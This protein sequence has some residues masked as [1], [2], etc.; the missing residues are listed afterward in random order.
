MTIFS[1]AYIVILIVPGIIFKRFFFQ[2]AFSGQFNSGLFADRLI[3]SL[4]LGILVQIISVLTF[5]RIIN[6]SYEDWRTMLQTLYHNILQ[7]KF[8]D[9]TLRQLGN[10][11]LYAIYSVVLAASLG[12]ILYKFIR[13]LRLDLKLPA[14][15]FLNQWHYYFKG[16]ILGTPEFKE[17][18]RGKVIST[19][20]DLMLKNNDGESNLFSGLLTQYT[21][22][23][24]NELDTL[25]LTGATRFSQ[26]KNAV[27]IIPG[28]IF[29]I[30]FS[31]VQNINIRYN[32]QLK[33]EQQIFKYI[34]ISILVVLL[35]TCFVYPWFMEISIWKKLFGT[36][37]LFLFW[38][39]L[40]SF[41]MSF[42]PSD[43]GTKRP[44]IGAVIINILMLIIFLIFSILILKGI[45]F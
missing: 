31:T 30:P 37:T 16:E 17:T 44:S 39:F 45:I 8:P 1:F 20:V 14:F 41:I 19:E 22:N 2:G 7:S 12:F 10:V 29:I 4:F 43:T 11:L 32:F 18:Q 6:V 42:F 26:S 33:K 9:I 15:R 21:L 27:I 40:S 28:D 23:A 13:W 34:I 38:L 36:L 25:Y 5:S 24:Q 35:L 3:T